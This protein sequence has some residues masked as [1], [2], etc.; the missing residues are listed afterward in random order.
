MI[1]KSL[2]RAVALYVIGLLFLL[3]LF[4]STASS[5]LLRFPDIHENTVVFVHGEDIWSVPADGGVATRLTIHDGQEQH[6]KFSPDGELIAFS[7]E[8]DGNTDVYVMNR[9]GGEI[10]RVTYHPGNDRVVG[11]HP[12]KNKIMFVARRGHFRFTNLFLINPDGSG[13]EEVALHNI[14][15]GSFS[16]DGKQIAYNR[17]N[18]EGRTWKRYQGGN[19]QEIYIYDFAT[20]EDKNLTNFIGTDRIPMWMGDKVYFTSDRDRVLNLHSLDPVSGEIVKLTDHASYDIR[21]PSMGSGKIVYELGGAL[22][23]YDTANQSGKEIPVEIHTD[24]PEVRSTY[25]NAND[26][27]QGFNIS[28]SGKR[29]LVIGRGELFSIPK[30]NGPTRNLTQSSGARDKDGDWSPDGKQ[31]AYLSDANGEYDIYLVDPMGKKKAVQLTKLGPG[32]RHTLRWSPDSKKIAFTDQTLTLNIIDVATKKISK[33]DRAEYENIDVGLD[34]KPIYDFQWSPDSRFITY[35]KMTKDYIYQICVYG[36]ETGKVHLVSDGLFNDF[37]P[38]FSKDGMRLFFASQRRFNPVFCDFEWEMVYKKSTGIYCL[39]LQKNA[40]PFL[41]LKSDEESA[42]KKSKDKADPVLIDFKGI[43]HRIEALP[44][45]QSNYRYLTAGDGVLF[46]L[47]GEEGDFNR[48]E[49]RLPES[50]NLMAFS[51]KSHKAKGVIEG[52]GRYKLSA[53]G[54][55]IVYT[56]DEGVGIISSSDRE[57]DGKALS[58]AGMRMLLNPREEW[59][60]I[61]NEAWRMERDFYYEPDMHGLDWDGMKAKYGALIPHASCRQDVGFIIGELIGELNTSHTYVFGGER[62]RR[63]DR[64]NVGLLGADYEVDQKA[65]L[66]RFKKILRTSGWTRGTYPPLAKPGLNIKKGD[67]LLQVNGVDVK[68]DR[69]VFAYFQNLGGKQ[70]TLLINS[71]PA[72]QGAREV[73]VVPARTEGALRYLDWVEEN[74]RKVDKLSDGKIGYIHMP[75]TYTGSAREFP[76]YFYGQ[77]QKQ[78]IILDGRFN[79]GGLDPAMFLQRLRKKPWMYWTRR[80]SH[81]QT[82]PHL[83]VMAHMVCLTN[84]QAGSGGDMLPWEFQY[85][86]MGPVIGTTT[87]GGLVGVSMFLELIDGGGLTAPDYRVYDPDGDWTVEN[88][89]VKPDIIV[90]LHPAEMAKGKDAQLMRGIHEL[91][92]KIKTDPPAWPQHGPFPKDKLKN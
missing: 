77:T 58:L 69:S 64:V 24:L 7:G 53:D 86:G 87:W 75:D 29:A 26:H 27:I 88:E 92:Q 80:Y 35:S 11:W 30:K 32:Y 15:Q 56:K 41:P 39:T 71:K 42:S 61:F 10:T 36:M 57:S 70:V 68:A 3:P 9:H 82:S 1:Q 65:G 63:A 90:D 14:S 73:V 47:D 5:P 44:L 21:R 91:L 67:Y 54:S 31:I 72:V 50:M 4:G 19:A 66:Y 89:G 17:V 52:I 84:R 25:V 74:R 46:Y 83:P 49:Y 85:F 59:M 18:R 76:K 20:E 79:G 22:W 16:P 12:T 37:H 8:Y 6:P 45:P 55:S 51:F 28:P 34:V 2:M 40:G 38:T 43:A 48:F 62:E 23:M 13:L 33:V 81:D 60:Q 78:G